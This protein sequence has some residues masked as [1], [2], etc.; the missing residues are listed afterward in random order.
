MIATQTLDDFRRADVFDSRAVIERIEELESLDAPDEDEAAEL[1]TL[2]AFADEADGYI[3]DWK[4]GEAFIADSYFEDYAREL[5][6]DIGAIDSNA[7]WPLTYI[8][9]PAAA[10][11]LKEDYTSID[12]DGM[13]FWAR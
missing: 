12:L 6:D 11:A 4:Y 2:R 1:V 10:D 7:T 3:D 5:A 8:D 13:T 9:W